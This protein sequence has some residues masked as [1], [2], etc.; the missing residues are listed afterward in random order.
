MK[1]VLLVALITAFAIGPALAQSCA[2]K[3]V[4][5]EGRPLVGAAKTSFI[6]KCKQDACA[7]K[8]MSNDGKP[9]SGAAKNSFMRKCA[10]SA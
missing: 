6:K 4:S 1:R 7:G 2:S 3:A 9:L 8:A 5:K 10:R